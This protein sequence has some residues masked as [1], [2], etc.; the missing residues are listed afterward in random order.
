M[1]VTYSRLFHAFRRSNA[2][3][4]YLTCLNHYDVCQFGSRPSMMSTADNCNEQVSLCPETILVD[5][6][7][8]LLTSCYASTMREARLPPNR[9]SMREEAGL[10]FP[11]LNAPS[12]HQQLHTT[13]ETYPFPY[14]TSKSI[15][16]PLVDNHL[17][18]PAAR[19]NHL[20]ESPPEA[21][22]AST[23]VRSSKATPARLVFRSVLY[24]F[25]LRSKGL[26][27]STLQDFGLLSSP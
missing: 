15:S 10:S 11:P 4:P 16:K 1:R 25:A 3:V 12:S 26:W 5:L 18:W 20:A 8:F 21:R 17:Q 2:I 27:N 6:S 9:T 13:T 24:H 14:S 19:E 22:L 7:H 23:A